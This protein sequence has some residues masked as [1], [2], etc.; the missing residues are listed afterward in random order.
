MYYT[1][2]GLLSYLAFASAI[3]LAS[4]RL[5]VPVA[6]HPACLPSLATSIMKAH[7]VKKEL[8]KS[9]LEAEM[10]DH[11]VVSWPQKELLSSNSIW[12]EF[13]P[14][15]RIYD[16]QRVEVQESDAITITFVGCKKCSTP[17]SWTSSRGTQSLRK[18]NCPPKSVVA[19]SS[20][21]IVQWAR[22]NVQPT[23]AQK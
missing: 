18:H 8:Q 22:P 17:Y 23:A 15:V 11:V 20:H 4:A 14:V 13:G 3:S 16:N 6:W 1:T 21:S 5:P 19:S 12:D 9:L 7:E 2:C 10:P